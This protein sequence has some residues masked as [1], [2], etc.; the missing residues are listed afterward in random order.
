MRFLT[1]GL[2]I[3]LGIQSLIYHFVFLISQFNKIGYYPVGKIVEKAVCR[4]VF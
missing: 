1:I 2:G 4:S 3:D